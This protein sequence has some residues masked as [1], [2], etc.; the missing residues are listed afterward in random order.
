MEHQYIIQ[1]WWYLVGRSSRMVKEASFRDKSTTIYNNRIP[2]HLG[3]LLGGKLRSGFSFNNSVS[4][5]KK[6]NRGNRH[7]LVMQRERKWLSEILIYFKCLLLKV[8]VISLSKLQHWRSLSFTRH[9]WSDSQYDQSK[10][11]QIINNTQHS[12]QNEEK[13]KDC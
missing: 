9:S 2:N 13:R 5:C 8:S 7:Q 10:Q 3:R 1:F 12:L 6:R 11:W 4:L